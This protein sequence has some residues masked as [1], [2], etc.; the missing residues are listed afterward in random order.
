MERYPCSWIGIIN[1]VKMSIL[2]KA[3]YRFNAIPIKIPIPFFTEIE[4]TLLKFIW[5]HRRPQM[6]RAI[7]IKNKS[8]G[9]MHPNF[10]LYYKAISNQNSMVLE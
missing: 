7:L 6:A 2:I 4:K 10:K 9:I 3:I 8:R 5:Y 1:I